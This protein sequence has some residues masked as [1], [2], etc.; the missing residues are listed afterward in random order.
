[1]LLYKLVQICINW[2]NKI[3]QCFWCST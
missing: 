3:Y 1:M 2:N